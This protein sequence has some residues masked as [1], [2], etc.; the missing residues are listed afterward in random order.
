VV[1]PFSKKFQTKIENFTCENCG[2]FVKG[3][4]YTN[5]CPR[6]LWSKH[7][8]VN[9]GDREEGCGG[10]MKPEDLEIKKGEYLIHHKCIKCGFKKTNKALKDDSLEAIIKISNHK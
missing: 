5:H 4:G 10:L 7:V 2:F 8:D 3:D 6:C 9:P 1:K